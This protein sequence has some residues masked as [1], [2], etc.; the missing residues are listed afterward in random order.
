[1]GQDDQVANLGPP[2]NQGHSLDQSANKKR[3]ACGLYLLLDG[4]EESGKPDVM[5]LISLSHGPHEKILNPDLVQLEQRNDTWRQARGMT[6]E[7]YLK[8]RDIKFF[9][10]SLHHLNGHQSKASRQFH[11]AGG[12]NMCGQET[13]L[14]PPLKRRKTSEQLK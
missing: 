9:E 6:N 13:D 12:L 1:M 7:K 14:L 2:G 11:A 3:Q 4:G 10:G 5:R 8:R